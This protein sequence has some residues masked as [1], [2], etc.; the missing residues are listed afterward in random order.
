MSQFAQAMQQFSTTY[1]AVPHFTHA[2]DFMQR[3]TNIEGFTLE[4]NSVDIGAMVSVIRTNR[5]VAASFLS[6]GH[7]PLVMTLAMS[8]GEVS[9]ALTF[10]FLH[11]EWICTSTPINPELAACLRFAQ[12]TMMDFNAWTLNSLTLD[13]VSEEPVRVAA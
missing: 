4:M 12:G 6:L 7:V 10:S 9:E 2:S 11:E 3:A 5:D 1:G 8:K 13:F